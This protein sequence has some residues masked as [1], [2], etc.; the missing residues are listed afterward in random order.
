MPP[1]F[2]GDPRLLELPSNAQLCG[3]ARCRREPL[4]G[5]LV[6]LADAAA[7]LLADTCSQLLNHRSRRQVHRCIVDTG[8][9]LNS[10][11]QPQF[12][13]SCQLLVSTRPNHESTTMNRICLDNLLLLQHTSAV[14]SPLGR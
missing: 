6:L 2:G 11:E 10:V 5:H 8:R 12:E 3:G 9:R 1:R 4:Q 13:L 7:G 14:S